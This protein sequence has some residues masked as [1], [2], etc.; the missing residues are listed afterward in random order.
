M[1]SVTDA[2]RPRTG[3]EMLTTANEIRAAIDE[4]QMWFARKPYGWR[5]KASPEQ[6]QQW[7][8]R[9]REESYLLDRLAMVEE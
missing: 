4:L 7:A 6:L 3:D 9:E 5:E 2:T 8:D 1:T